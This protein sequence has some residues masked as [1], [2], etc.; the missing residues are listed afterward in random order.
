MKNEGMEALN[1]LHE[2]LSCSLCREQPAAHRLRMESSLRR[3]ARD[4]RRLLAER[5]PAVERRIAEDE[6]R[7]A[8]QLL[9]EL[10]RHRAHT[11]FFKVLGIFLTCGPC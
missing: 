6:L 3:T 5:L 2:G 7:D 10:R 4:L 1:V 11:A 9:G 8:A